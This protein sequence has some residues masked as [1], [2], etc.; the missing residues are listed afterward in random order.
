MKRIWIH[1]ASALL[2]AIAVLFSGIPLNAQNSRGPTL[3]PP[4]GSVTIP[5][6][7]R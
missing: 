6:F 1:S 4:S 3:P 5:I 7:F 2:L